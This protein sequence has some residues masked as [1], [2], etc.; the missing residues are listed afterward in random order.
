MKLAARRLAVLLN[1]V[2]LIMFIAH[3]I[4]VQVPIDGWVAF[5]M[6][7]VG[8]LILFLAGEIKE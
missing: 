3:A 2:A 1:I 8:E 4:G 6:W 7:L 5:A